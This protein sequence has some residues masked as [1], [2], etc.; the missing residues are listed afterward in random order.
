[1]KNYI[2]ILFLFYS[3]LSFGQIDSLILLPDQL[4]SNDIIENKITP[5]QE[6]V[7]SASRSLKTL[8]DLPFTIYVI[9][10][11]EIQRYGYTTLVDVVRMLPGIKV[12]QPGS[13]LEGELF[14]MRGLMGN[15]HTK[16]LIN[17]NPIKPSV[18]RGM[19]IGAQLPIQQAERIEVIYGPAATLYGADASAGIINIIMDETERP[20]YAQANLKVGSQRFMNLDITF[21]GKLYKGKNTLHY[22]FYGGYTFLNDHKV[23]DYDSLYIPDIYRDV[24][25]DLA[26]RDIPNYVSDEQGSPLFTNMPH[27]SR[28]IGMDLKY[29]ALNFSASIL[30]R[31]DHSSLGL[32]PNAVAFANPLNFTGERIVSMNLSLGKTYKKFSYKATASYLQYFMDNQS[33]TTY[34]NNVQYQKLTRATLLNLQFE[35]P[36]IG[37]DTMRYNTLNQYYFDRYFSESR[38]SFAESHDFSLD[39]SFN[40]FPIKN[41]EITTGG[42]LRT[43]G[44]V[45]LVQFSRVPYDNGVF[46]I[47]DNTPNDPLLVPFS[48]EELTGVDITTFLQTQVTLGKFSF[49]GGLQYYY[50]YES[51]FSILSEER[52]FNSFNPRLAVIYNINKRINLRAFYGEAFRKPSGFDYSFGYQIDPTRTV[53]PLNQFSFPLRP[54]KTRTMELGARYIHDSDKK[55]QPSI[56]LVLFYSQ[57]DNLIS[58]SVKSNSFI[59]PVTDTPKFTF[60]QGFRNSQISNSNLF[61]VGVQG[62]FRL[63]L[64]VNNRKI[65]LINSVLFNYGEENITSFGTQNFVREYPDYIN[66]LRI[67]GPITDNLSIGFERIRMSSAKN[68]LATG[69]RGDLDKFKTLDII[70]NYRLSR[71]FIGFF[72]LNNIRNTKYAGLNV[73]G[74]TDDLLFNPQ[75]GRT[76]RIGLNYSLN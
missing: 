74:T 29:R 56:D 33:S 76:F 51:N 2:T 20:V 59:D 18:V 22:M 62:S 9:S 60:Q 55:T 48:K 27:Q 12:S 67:F 65:E 21:G 40:F 43:F 71:N 61:L 6:K 64:Y 58:Y 36:G 35:T 11:E 44:S 23:Y 5:G 24:N 42:I 47:S 75:E 46:W 7:F 16:I 39:L 50:N 34:V 38:F 54:E 30:S 45:P 41:V 52:K 10:K 19:P 68:R 49:I 32:N 1:M 69:G 13:A 3:F 31:R 28:M 57:T 17:G 14:M 26:P 25:L 4:G 70:A 73:T 15:A 72:R 63:N 66:K 8:K 53:N 37:F